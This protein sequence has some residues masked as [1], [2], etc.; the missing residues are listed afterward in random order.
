M[1]VFVEVVGRDNEVD[2]RAA[3]VGGGGFRVEFG[4]GG[5]EVAE[6]VAEERVACLVPR[7]PFVVKFDLLAES[8]GALLRVEPAI[9][10]DGAAA[11]KFGVGGGFHFRAGEQESAHAFGIVGGDFLTDVVG[12]G[13]VSIGIAAEA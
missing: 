2:L 8:I 7:V 1:R 11:A 13:A 9:D 12:V 5:A 10:K 3:K 4:G 6:D